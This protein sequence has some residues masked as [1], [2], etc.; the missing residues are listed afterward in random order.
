MPLDKLKSFNPIF[1]FNSQFFRAPKKLS[2]G[3]GIF[4]NQ[5]HMSCAYVVL[6]YKNIA[7]KATKKHAIPD[8]LL[9]PHGPNGCLVSINFPIALFRL[10][11]DL[12]SRKPGLTYLQPHGC[13]FGV[14]SSTYPIYLGM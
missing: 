1:H 8:G 10:N 13:L 9:I 5:F 3:S 6:R 7:K 14:G 12:P 4:L 11:L 2:H